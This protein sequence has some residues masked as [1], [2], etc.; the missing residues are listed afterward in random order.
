MVFKLEG[1]P[2]ALALFAPRPV[3]T[4]IK[5]TEL[6]DYIPI[7]PITQGSPMTFTVSETGVEYLDVS[8]TKLYVK[9]KITHKNGDPVTELDKVGLSN[10]PL[11]SLFKQMDLLLGEKVITSDVATYYG[12]KALL[13]VL[14]Q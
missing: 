6:E 11:H 2:S 8:K 12:Q 5:R 3:Q 7:A 9:M 4:A 1:H 10:L 13:D 14:L